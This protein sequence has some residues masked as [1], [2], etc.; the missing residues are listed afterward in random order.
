MAVQSK[1]FFS[2]RVIKFETALK[3]IH[4]WTNFSPSL[5]EL[6]IEKLNIMVQSIVAAKKEEENQ[7]AACETAFADRQL[8]FIKGNNSI[9]KLG[10]IIQKELT[11]HSGKNDHVTKVVTTLVKKMR[12]IELLKLPDDPAYWDAQEVV[13]LSQQSYQNK[14]QVFEDI[15]NVM[16]SI[17]GYSSGNPD[18]VKKSLWYKLK[19]LQDANYKIANLIQLLIMARNKKDHI[20]AEMFERITKLKSET[21]KIYG[22]RSPEFM[23][24]LSL[25]F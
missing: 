3:F 22:E 8:L 21:E 19:Q 12:R 16:A 4:N 14:V 25:G 11:A 17:D 1:S 6:S 9:D 5:P 7:L 18:T 15:V 2:T 13:K 24:L 10:T 20:H 23:S